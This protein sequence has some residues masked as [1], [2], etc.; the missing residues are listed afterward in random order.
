MVYGTVS[1]IE[2]MISR[3]EEKIG[4]CKVLLTGGNALY[5]KDVLAIDFE[6]NPDL[7]IEGLIELY[8]NNK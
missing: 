1:M 5:I 4:K 3:I 6:Y 7:L 8:D 2:G